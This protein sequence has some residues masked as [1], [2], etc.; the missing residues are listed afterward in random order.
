[1]CITSTTTFRS[2][3]CQRRWLRF[4]SSDAGPHQ[5]PCATS[6]PAFGSNFGTPANNEWLWNG[7]NPNDQAHEDP[8]RALIYDTAILLTTEW[9]QRSCTSR[10]KR[11]DT[12]RGDQRGRPSRKR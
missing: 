3:D 5:R 2:T 11:P 8:M 10:F 4:P 6:P 1:M 12:G 7:T 9:Y